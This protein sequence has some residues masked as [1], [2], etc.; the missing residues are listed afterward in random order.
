VRIWLITVGE[1]LPLGGSDVRLWR[2]GLLAQELAARGH[3][4]LWW[5]SR[6][7]HFRKCF[8]AS[9]ARVTAQRGIE[10]Q[11]L[12]GCLYRRNVSLA[13]LRNHA[14]IGRDFRRLSAREPEPDV[15]LCSLPTLELCDEAVSYGRARGIPVLLDVRDLWPD[16]MLARVPEPLRPLGRLALAPLY[17]KA[18]RALRG[19]TG[20]VAISR[21]YLCW[22]EQ[23]RGSAAGPDDLVAPIGYPTPAAAL[24]SAPG[25]AERMRA[26]GVDPARKI[27]WFCGTFVG[28]I[29]LGTAIEAARLVQRERDLQFV[30]SGDGERRSEWE[31]Q[32]RGLANVVFTGWCDK[33]DLAWL[34]RHAW[35]GLAAY[36][37][38]ALMSLPN[39]LFEYMSA[40]LPIVSSLG[41]EAAELIVRSELGRSFEAGNADDLAS[42]LRDLVASPEATA[43]YAANARAAFANEFAA[44]RLYARLAEHLEARARGDVDSSHGPDSPRS[45]VHRAGSVIIR[46]R[47]AL[48]FDTRP[49]DSII[50]QPFAAG[51]CGMASGALSAPVARSA[52]RSVGEHFVEV[53][54][55]AGDPISREQLERM[56][57]RYAWA[58]PYCAG[59]DVVEVA[60]GSGP[61]LGLLSAAAR[62][63]EAGDVSEPI[64]ALARWHY[65]ER[66]PLQRIDAHALPLE[67]ASK[68]VIV[69]FEAI[70][71]L[72]DPS[73]FVAECGRVLRSGGHALV[74]TANKDLSDF[75]PSPHSH[76]YYG[77]VELC[78][79]F[80]SAGFRVELF[81]H[82]SVGAVGWRQRALRPMKRSLVSLGLMPKTMRGKRLLKRLVFGAPL[83]MPAELAM[84]EVAPAPPSRLS[85]AR[86]DREH[87]VLYLAARKP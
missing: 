10:L 37:P 30:L 60:C 22:A 67:A 45:A 43:R 80:A 35:I 32:A 66:V 31:A 20:V 52:P 82:L 57:H 2:T 68:D 84:P 16:E 71:Y 36:K 46:S 38:R 7:D 27:V 33:A 48:E 56:Q 11:L 4:V 73:R 6:V 17:R 29:D 44:E 87:K 83:P 3:D 58:A 50:R 21:A 85:G 1:P 23:L 28:S 5:T 81:G 12:D 77:A 54:E 78:E 9:E 18:R 61:G 47:K 63:L 42:V 62:S 69:L 76:T 34:S 70:Y 72:A 79:L 19:A 24:D 25:V 39:K 13:R 51:G 74:A 53:S 26:K 14:Q 55:L 8:H 59:R 65:G 15:I 41:A 40:G 75:N 49:R 64:L 86:S